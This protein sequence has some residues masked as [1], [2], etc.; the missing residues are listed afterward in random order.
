LPR[1]DGQLLGVG[2]FAPI[3]TPQPQL[4]QAY[5]PPIAHGVPDRDTDSR[6]YS[7]HGQHPRSQSQTS[8]FTPEDRGFPYASV[9]QPYF[10][11]PH[12]ASQSA[13]STTGPRPSS[14]SIPM[15]L[16]LMTS[17]PSAPPPVNTSSRPSINSSQP[18]FPSASTPQSQNSSYR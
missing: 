6:S 10:P 9:P 18:Y 12:A 17:L 16:T 4:P 5:L 13:T 15:P 3:A 7:R 14:H 2:R 11:V 1:S 8:L